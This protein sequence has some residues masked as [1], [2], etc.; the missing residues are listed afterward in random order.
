MKVV[1][2]QLDKLAGGCSKI[3]VFDCE[4]WH[5]LSK[6]DYIYPSES[7]FFFVPR[8]I[9]GFLLTKEKE[10]WRLH[11][12]F[13]VTFFPPAL[14]V[15]LP[16]SKY[17]TVSEKTANK[18]NDLEELIGV[19]WGEAFPSELSAD[20]KKMHKEALKLYKEDSNIEKH[21]K[22][23]AW[24]KSFFKVYSESMIVVKGRGDID[25]LQ[26][27]AKY[28]NIPYQKYLKITDIADWNKASYRKCKTAKL[29]GTFECIWDEL[30]SET[31]QIAKHL[32]LVNPHEPTTDASMTFIIALFITSKGFHRR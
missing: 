29:E 4:F 3:L 9:G 15:A 19:P 12:S 28:Y 18:L 6:G 32:P 16:I 11:P 30:D 31:K 10:E 25:A 2:T 14:D 27:I 13:C 1:H 23:K 17:A 5:V 8:E 20:Q 26:N 24:Y 7:D 22:T 21:H